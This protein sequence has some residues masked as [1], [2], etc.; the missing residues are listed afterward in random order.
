[1]TVDLSTIDTSRRTHRELVAWFSSP[2]IAV[3]T[4]MRLLETV[5]NARVWLRRSEDH[6]A[7][8]PLAAISAVI[9][10]TWSTMI[11]RQLNGLGVAIMWDPGLDD[12]AAPMRPAA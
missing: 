2:R 9:P 10:W 5:P 4:A 12:G 1:M 6:G 7:E 11:T 8:G 3:R